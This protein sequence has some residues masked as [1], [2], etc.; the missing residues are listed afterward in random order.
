MSTAVPVAVLASS[1]AAMA[2]QMHSM[3]IVWNRP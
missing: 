3:A 1:S 2:V